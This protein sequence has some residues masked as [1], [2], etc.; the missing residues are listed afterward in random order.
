MTTYRVYAQVDPSPAPW[1]CVLTTSD[2][3][4]LVATQADFIAAGVKVRV[5]TLR[6]KKR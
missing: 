5:E 2:W 6:L 1:T 4:Y 3:D